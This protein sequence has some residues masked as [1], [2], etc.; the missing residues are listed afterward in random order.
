MDLYQI[1][2]R[3]KLYTDI[4]RGYKAGAE[5][6]LVFMVNATEENVRQSGYKPDYIFNF[7]ES[8]Y[9]A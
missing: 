2:V 5:T 8:L 7:I 6:A 4:H 9:Q 1:V 3:D